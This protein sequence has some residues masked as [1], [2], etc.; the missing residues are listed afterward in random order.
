MINIKSLLLFTLNFLTFLS[1]EEIIN[2]PIKI[3]DHSY[4]IISSKD[5]KYIVFTSGEV[6]IVDKTN[7]KIE[8]SSNFCEYS[9]PYVYGN[10]ESNQYFIYS[11]KKFC[12]ISDTYTFSYLNKN[13]LTFSDNNKYI[14]YIK[15]NEYKG[16]VNDCRCQV[17][18]NE[19]IIYGKKGTDHIIFTFIMKETNYDIKIATP[20]PEDK[21]VCIL[22]LNSLYGCGV[23]SN[24][25]I[26]FYLYGI[27]PKNSVI[28]SS[29]EIKQLKYYRFTSFTSHTE[30]EIYKESSNNFIF[31]LCA[32][33]INTNIIECLRCTLDFTEE[34]QYS[35]CKFN[36]NLKLKRLFTFQKE[37]SNNEDCILSKFEFE[38]LY[39]CGGINNIKCERIKEDF[40][41]LYSFKLNLE[42]VNSHLSLISSS[43][44]FIS[45]FYVNRLA[46]I[47]K[48]YEYFIYIP[49]CI[50]KE[51]TIISYHSINENKSENEDSI[52]NF[53]TRK[54]NT[55]YY[56]E[57][58]NLPLE[59]GNLKLDNE[60]IDENNNKILID[61]N[62]QNI[63]DF[64]STNE[65]GINNFI[66]NY[67]I[68]LYETYSSQCKITLN[69]LPCYKSCHKCSKDN[70]LSSL[71]EHNCLIN[72]CKNDY[73]K[74]PTKDTNCFKI[75]EKKMNWY[76]DYSNEKFGICDSS[77]RSCEGP[78]DNE[79]LTCYSTNE[80]SNH[81]YL[82]NK[83]CISACPNKTFKILEPGGYYSCYD[84]YKNCKSCSSLGNFDDMKCDTCEENDIFFL[85][86]GLKN[87]FKEYDVKTKKFYLP[88]N[89]QI[90]SCYE[91]FSYYIE[92][93]TYE[94][95]LQIPD[96]Y[97]ISNQ[98]TGIFS[99]CHSNC[100]TCS[101]NY[102][103]NSSNCDLCK[104]EN[105]Y[106]FEGNC[107]ENCLNGYY[108]NETNNQKTCIKC[109]DN[110]LKCYSTPIYNDLNK[111][112]NMNCISCKKDIDISNSNNLIE[113]YIF[114]DKN[115]FT[116][117]TYTNEKIIFD[118]SEI[119]PQMSQKTCL[120]YEKSI[121]YGEYKCITKPIN[122][123]Y[124]LNNEENTGVIK[125][126]DDACLTC[127]GEKNII[128][129]DTNCINCNNGYFKT[130]DSNTNCI[131][132]NQI[133]QNY[134]K[135]ENNNIYYHCYKYCGTCN[136]SYDS[137][138]NNM[139]CNSCIDNYYFIYGTNNCYNITFVNNNSYFFSP[140]D[141]KF[142][143]CY[144][145]CKKCSNYGND[146]NNQNCDI[147]IDNYYFEYNT[148]NCYNISYL[149]KGYYL[150][151]FT[152]DYNEL[153]KFKKCYENCG[154]CSN[155]L[156][157]NNMNCILCKINYYKI[158]GTNNCY[159]NELS[160]QGYYLKDNIF[161][162]C[163]ANCLTCSDKKEILDNNIVVNNCLSCDKI[164][165]GLYL[166]YDLKI[167][168][169]I[170][171]KNNG[172]YLEEDSNN[173]EIFYKC[174]NKCSL[175]NKGK[176]IDNNK[177]IHNCEKC[178]EN[179]YV[180]RDD[181][182]EQCLEYNNQHNVYA[183][184]KNCYG[185]EMISY[186]YN[187]RG[188][189]WTICYERCETCDGK[190]IYD[191]NNEIINQN[192]LSCFE[193]Y[194]LIY[195]SK[196]CVNDSILEY[197]YY[198]DD[199][200]LKYH[201]CD[202]QC[203]TCIKFSEENYS[204]CTSCNVEQ[205]YYPAYDKP[206]YN[207]YNKDT[208]DIGY[209]LSQVYDSNTGMMNKL[210][211]LCY[212]T[213][214]S[215]FSVGN[216]IE[217]NCITCK[218]RYYLIYNT[219]NCVSNEY[220]LENNYYFN[221]I[222]GQFI[223]C[224]K[225]CL[226]CNE[227]PTKSNTNCLKCNQEKGYYPIKNKSNSMCYSSETI[228]EGYYLDIFEE[229]YKWEQCYEYCG[230]CSF[231]GTKKKMN[232]KSCKT[233]IINEKTNKNIYFK[234]ING[235]CIES[236]PEGL[237]MTYSGD[238]IETCPNQTYGFIPNTS[239]INSCPINYELSP[240]GKMCQL[241]KLDDSIT[242]AVFRKMISSN[243]SEYIDSSKVINGSNFKAQIIP[244]SKLDPLEQIKQGISGIDLGN[245][246]NILK[247]R[248]NIP[249][250]EDLIIIEIETKEDKEKNKNLNKKADFVNL[251]KNVQ[252]SVYDKSG[253]KLDISYC[254]GD[255]KIMKYIADLEGV[256]FDEAKKYA[257]E[258]IDVFN[259]KDSFFNDICHP[260]TSEKGDVILSDRREDLFQNVSFCGEGCEY[261]G[262]DFELMIAKCDCDPANIQSG[263]G[264]N[265]EI[266]QNRKGVTM[267]DIINSFTDELFS[268]NF[269][270]VKC[271]NLVFDS[272]I[273]KSNI[274]F[275]I[276]IILISLEIFIFI[277]FSK[278]WLKP[279]RNYMLVFE[280]F[281]PNI[282]PPNPPK[283]FRKHNSCVYFCK[284]PNFTLL[285]ELKNNNNKNLNRKVKESKK[286]ILTN[287]LNSN[288]KIPKK[289][290]IKYNDYMSEK[291][292]YKRYNKVND[293]NNESVSFHYGS[294]EENSNKSYSI[295]YKKSISNSNMSKTDSDLDE[296][297]KSKM[298]ISLYD[299]NEDDKSD[300]S[301]SDEIDNNSFFRNKTIFKEE[302]DIK[303]N[304]NN[305]KENNIENNDKK[306]N[307]KKTLNKKDESPTKEI[308]DLLSRV[309][310]PIKKR[311]SL[312]NQLDTI[313]YSD[314]PSPRKNKRVFKTSK[315]EFKNKQRLSIITRKNS[316]PEIIGEDDEFEQ[317]YENNQIESNKINIYKNKN[318]KYRNIKRPLKLG[319]LNLKEIVSTDSLIE[320]DENNIYNK[321][322][323]K[324]NNKNE[325][326]TKSEMALSTIDTRKTTSEMMKDSNEN[327]NNNIKNKLGNMK[328]KNKKVN[329]AYTDEEFLD[330]EFE[331]ARH[332]D[333]RPFIR[334]YWSYL[335]EEHIILNTFFSDSYL[336]L[337]IIKLSFLIFSFKISFFLNAFFYT[338][339]YIS[340]SYNNDG[341]L[342]FI[343]SLPK[344]IYS[345][346][347]TIIVSNLLKLLSNS[348]KQFKDII[349]EKTIKKE[350]LEAMYSTLKKLRNKLI[351]YFI[352]LFVFGIFFL[353]Y[354]TS[355]CA[356]YQG[357]QYY[358]LYGC[359]ESLVMDIITPFI[360]SLILTTL[361][362]LGLYKH[363]KCLYSLSNFL[364]NIF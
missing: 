148:K 48:V 356:V 297:I 357:S 208:I 266:D 91:Q 120:D 316:I 292:S 29:C 344:A 33:N 310:S 210:W 342:D 190:E 72:N 295:N 304:K 354:V 95:V 113:K 267:N 53:F 199:N 160:N 325:K 216:S 119:Y 246:I 10:D 243:L 201:K 238:C 100:K 258:G 145:I 66:I 202:I 81:A 85:K 363:S 144:H 71:E 225:A 83:K 118:V 282:D 42:G 219:T 26:Y 155:Y 211:I 259:G 314:N 34:V 101:Q 93:N 12:L 80:N 36:F 159:S 140:T 67:K 137:I 192:C 183:H 303:K 331:Q 251:G 129:Q 117:V 105:Y 97:Y 268:F 207:C 299:K 217:N 213:C 362:F 88:E 249:N 291:E 15:E 126:C 45:I 132:E 171:Y 138:N 86:N 218:A 286:I 195:N 358:W 340:E 162:P 239:C 57:F 293:I 5:D 3:S 7:G 122:S 321:K 22:F 309:I 177:E 278:D 78:S 226:N 206:Q 328:L 250:E 302:K 108:L 152:I 8:S 205:F 220:A 19:V 75:S 16:D 176:E 261:N 317:Y 348:K 228:E 285:D 173:V 161:Y 41:V 229:P 294:G 185:N 55:K 14:G 123:F 327:K 351:I 181:N 274:G 260:F 279:V 290:S 323:Q 56:I 196:N 24:G 247:M 94:C 52:N 187:L 352:C 9:P 280:P 174:Y 96:G 58:E 31:I 241:S 179:Y 180:L 264:D 326:Y 308:S 253:K 121:V 135:N 153:P 172:Y 116:I 184:P 322:K 270:V 6:I 288:K 169:P 163:E 318:I 200:D 324:E 182:C 364:M 32:K 50:N 332:Y 13:S 111:L 87:C 74:D 315:K 167:C 271:Y 99:P 198:Y 44:T 248:Y 143:K 193:G 334:M 242:P 130:E 25:Q 141:N 23:I 245:C 139:N 73:Y 69:I 227:G 98:I 84:C 276:M 68:I 311:A 142:H 28:N 240:D 114:L 178:I 330:M 355:F 319:K 284:N 107:I 110:C 255:I 157:D 149:E 263:E 252:I 60:I 360:F 21:I 230:S 127:N 343:T 133:P 204:K 281:D 287:N 79:C 189:Y 235:N 156:I 131:I 289:N 306:I 224:D 2:N 212:S 154:T 222:Y 338:D 231:K 18:K 146:D 359:L 51:Y 336:D 82:Y 191:E 106:L 102:T 147:C 236:C 301:K 256:D 35:K 244:S 168:E 333:N 103:E 353:Y 275:I 27:I 39:C 346:I 164:N 221:S 186:G 273:L 265:L 329:L 59:Y 20:N 237:F 214:K 54:T 262:I 349:R 307:L 197:G 38:Y 361:R 339:E 125:Y 337:R 194:H 335:L 65:K 46:S 234:L 170:E 298:T 112:T 77:C 350:Y 90:S 62:N 165:K 233:N 277:Y 63:L 150:D 341:V 320:K 312:K 166:V 345:G 151:T 188:N 61:E 92:E 254:N 11:S 257:G 124:I 215:C 272:S 296:D 269:I 109:H 209:S 40:G 17:K 136:G 89:N 115:C 128:A 49:D 70:S 43:S 64:I 347:V 175:C 4:P 300:L 30:V 37:E 313:D 223:K 104:N 232:C 283:K 47:D 1:N 305:N 76:F 203:K 134:Y 158:N